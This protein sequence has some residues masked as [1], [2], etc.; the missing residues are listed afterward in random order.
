MLVL[1][2]ISFLIEGLLYVPRLWQAR[3]LLVLLPICLIAF[4]LG[5]SIFQPLNLEITLLLATSLF[6]LLNLLRIAEGR[7]HERYLYRVARQTSLALIA[8]QSLVVGGT[9]LLERLPFTVTNR[10]TWFVLAGAQLVAAIV[11]LRVS[12]RSLS[13]MTIHH[14]EKQ[15]AGKDLPT[16]SVAVPARNETATLA[17]CLTSILASDYPKL[18]VLVLDDCSQ[19]DTNLIIRGFAQAG[20][21]FLH[22]QEP[23]ERWLAKNQAYQQLTEAATGD[24]ILFAGVDV[25][26]G[27][28]TI[29]SLIYTIEQRQ[30]EMICVLPM[31]QGGVFGSMFQPMRYWWELALPRRIFNRPAVLSTCWLIRRRAIKRLG[32]FGAVSRAVVPEAHF[33]RGLAQES[34]GYSFIRASDGVVV[35]SSKKLPD[36]YNLA[37]R[38]RYP[39]VHRRLELVLI[40]LLAELGL[41]LGPFL[42]VPFALLTRNFWLAGLTAGAVTLLLVA[43][44]Q[45]LRVSSQLHPVL[46]VLNFPV[47]VV[48]EV[49]INMI[50]MIRYEF[51]VVDWKG[52]NICLPVMH[53]QPSKKN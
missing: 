44:Y 32:G 13:K 34:D 27:P 22:G 36:Q 39:E 47:I 25:E 2:G 42:L 1:L 33:A 53:A 38:T 43:H 35:T 16:V 52:R 23:K 17:T 40:R 11:V 19:D 26:V 49:V 51:S 45:I 9:W 10:S 7:M 20:V 28:E 3:K 50:S 12:S 8:F 15:L 30:K 18:E 24:Y 48:V 21:R 29:R 5:F 46:M 14:P 31:H 4:T 37:V 41:L 6:R